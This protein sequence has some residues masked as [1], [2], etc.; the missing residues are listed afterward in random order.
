[1]ISG[2]WEQFKFGLFMGMGLIC[3]YGL[4]MLIVWLINAIAAGVH[5]PLPMPGRQ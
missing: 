1:M 5:S 2:A 3:A 4:L